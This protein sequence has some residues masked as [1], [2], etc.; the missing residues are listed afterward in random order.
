M[1]RRLSHA[2]L[3]AVSGLGLVATLALA[4]PPAASA[5]P[6]TDPAL[7]TKLNAVLKD[8]RVTRA[9]SSAIVLDAASGSTLYSR[10][11]D[12]ATMPASNTKV[13]TALAAMDTLG[14]DF[15]F[16]TQVIR[17]GAVS[18]GTVNGRLYLKGYGDPTTRRADYEALARAVQR[19]GIKRVKT[20]LVVDAGYFDSVRYNPTWRTSYAASY[21]AAEVSALTVAANTD[22]DPGTVYLKYKPG[23]KGSKAKVTFSPAAAKNHINLRNLTT[24][25]ARGSGSTF[26]ASRSS[27]SNTI[28]VR[29]RV[30]VGRST[31]QRLI[32]VHRPELYAGAVFRKELADL[33]ITVGGTIK[34]AATPATSRTV[35]ATDYSMKLSALLVPFMKLSNNGHAEALTKTMGAVRTG[36]GSWAKGLAYQRGYLRQSGA[37]LTGIVLTDGSGL[38]RSNKLTPRA[39]AM[40]L[41]HARSESWF[42]AFFN[43][44]PVAGNR[45]RMVGGTLR[46]RMNGTR[47]ANN[48]RAK[49]G[50][51][52]GVTAL[53]G[54]VR[55]RGGRLYA[56]SM[57]SEHNGNSPRPVENTFVTALANW[58]R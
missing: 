24:T 39:L 56:F 1:P 14:P 47:A 15:R 6:V 51:L 57:L 52:T 54:Y 37:S 18:A 23:K 7:V 2:L 22:L 43:S 26:S 42:P 3:T 17:R 12:R 46:N 38:T 33:G 21:Y 29:G 44:M 30:A 53:S 45:E 10:Y 48:A 27:G 55:G 5:A 16:K 58:V 40:A 25:S 32:T 28:T 34:A 4:G 19:A 11:G 9:K 13:V 20:D 8:S 41:R 36:T 49:T 31:A 50:T 35:I